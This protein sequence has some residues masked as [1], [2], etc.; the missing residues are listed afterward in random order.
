[1]ISMRNLLPALVFLSIFAKA[2]IAAEEANS[3]QS[4]KSTGSCMIEVSDD[5]SYGKSFLEDF[6]LNTVGFENLPEDVKCFTELA[7]NC[8][9]YGGESNYSPEREKQIIEGIKKYCSMAQN[10]LRALKIKYKNQAKI[11]RILKVCDVNEVIDHYA[12]ANCA[13]FNIK[14][15]K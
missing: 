8:E 5:Y 15:Y 3:T 1:M 2:S 4:L 12:P 9:H 7:A 11:Q 14:H 10:S 13:G 6:R